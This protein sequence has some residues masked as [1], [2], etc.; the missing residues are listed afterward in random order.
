RA[1]ALWLLGG[2]ESQRLAGEGITFQ[3][4]VPQ[5]ACQG[6]RLL[7]IAKRLPG[8]P[9]PQMEYAQVGERCR[10]PGA[11]FGL[12]RGVKKAL[13]KLARLAARLSLQTH[14]LRNSVGF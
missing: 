5:L 2:Q 1:G 14:Q 12:P 8:L 3:R 9:L 11:I 6:K 13:S 7:E 4:A 10:F